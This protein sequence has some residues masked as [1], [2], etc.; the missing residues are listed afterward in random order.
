MAAIAGGVSTE[1]LGVGLEAAKPAHITPKPIPYGS[2]GH[3]RIARRYA[4]INVQAA[5]AVLVAVRNV[6][7]N[8]IILT[9]LY[10]RL[11]QLSN[12]TAAIEVRISATIA[13]GYTVSDSTNGT[14]L[15]LTG[16]NTKKRTSMATCGLE[17]R[18]TAA[19]AGATGGTKT[20]DNDPFMLMSLWEL[21]TLPTGVPAP[22]AVRDYEPNIDDGDHP[23][24]FAQNEGFVIKNDVVLGAAAAGILYYEIGWA[25]VTTY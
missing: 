21:A 20:A 14:A 1:V 19:A 3:Y 6:A 8:P 16:N 25:E 9:K 24:I 23:Y 4:L 2:L 12:P 15:T 5:G 13:R 18:E 10:L 11:V 22:E 7:V 17:I